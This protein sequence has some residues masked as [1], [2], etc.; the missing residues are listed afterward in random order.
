MQL[1]NLHLPTTSIIP[2]YNGLSS[3]TFITLRT[4]PNMW[5]FSS[6]IDLLPSQTWSSGRFESNLI[7][8]PAISV[9]LSPWLPGSV[10]DLAKVDTSFPLPNA[11]HSIIVLWEYRLGLGWE[12]N[13]RFILDMYLCS[14]YR[15]R[16]VSDRT[17][18][19]C[20]LVSEHFLMHK[21]SN[22][23]QIDFLSDVCWTAV[24]K[25]V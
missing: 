24:G 9:D 2:I 16:S 10:T 7:P 14:C 11:S 4:L 19:H 6:W 13:L 3:V 1:S 5:L 23:I 20:H 18:N 12:A 8:E 22:C 21:M 15:I 17:A 25:A